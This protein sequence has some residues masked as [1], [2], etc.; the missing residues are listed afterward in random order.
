MSIERGV[1]ENKERAMQV[2]DFSGL[3]WGNITPTDI[4]CSIDFNHGAAF[5]FAELKLA[6]TPT[7]NGQMEHYENLCKA[8]HDGGRPAA[9]FL[10]EHNIKDVK[11]DVPA[12]ASI[13]KEY[14]IN[15]GVWVECGDGYTLKEAIDWFKG[16]CEKK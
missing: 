10:C 3:K 11:I 4:D 15:G 5:V 2:N 14:C 16:E 9:A 13:V 7:K 8:I 1:I 12:H 6:D